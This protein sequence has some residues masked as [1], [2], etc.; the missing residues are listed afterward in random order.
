[1]APS[2]VS[3]KNFGVGSPAAPLQDPAI[4][5]EGTAEPAQLSAAEQEA[6]RGLVD[7]Y[8]AE[9]YDAS[10]EEILT[11]AHEHVSG[12]LV[13]TLSMEN[14]VLAE[15]ASRYLPDSE[16]LFLDTGYHFPETLDVAQQVED[17]YPQTLVRA[18]PLLTV[19]QQDA[20][21]GINLYG[22]DPAACCRMRKV[23]PL[24]A[25]MA[26]YTGW[27]TGL[28]RAD[29]P[30]RATTPALDLDA[31][32]RLKISPL[33]TW[34]LE[35]TDRYIEDNQLIVHPLT[36]AGYPSIGCAPCTAK[37][38]AGQDPRSGRWAGFTKTECGLH[39]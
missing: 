36:K 33:V 16:F 18:E 21:Y 3:F 7:R 11:W 34:S 24:A 19:G 12:R 23:E 37:V 29:S 13:V 30:L 15:L 25:S 10:A 28:R 38:E 8:A 2:P 4:S 17:R 39:T 20:R 14:T 9:L 1:M 35:D 32:G 6:N 31:N 5:P 27:I 26:P 22:S